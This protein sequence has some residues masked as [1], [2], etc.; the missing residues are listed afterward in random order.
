MGFFGIYP[1]L[2]L[3]FHMYMY[4]YMYTHMEA[5]N[6]GSLWIFAVHIWICFIK[7]RHEIDFLNHQD[8]DLFELDRMGLKEFSRGGCNIRNVWKHD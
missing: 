1:C 5:W 8:G 2:M 4:I 7:I 6:G 3:I